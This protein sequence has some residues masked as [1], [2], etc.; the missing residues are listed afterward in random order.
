MCACKHYAP[1]DM[2]IPKNAK[3]EMGHSPHKIIQF[4]FQKLI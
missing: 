3:S 4:F 1:N 2:R